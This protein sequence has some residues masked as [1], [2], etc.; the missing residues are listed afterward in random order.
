MFD[1]SND[2]SYAGTMVQ[3]KSTKPSLY[4]DWFCSTW[5]HVST[6]VTKESSGKYWNR[7]E[8]N[9][10]LKFLKLLLELRDSKKELQDDDPIFPI[11]IITPFA[12]M[13]KQLSH[14]LMESSFD[15][16]MVEC[17]TIHTFQGKEAP[18]VILCLVCDEEKIGKSGLWVNR[19]PHLINVAVTRAKRR[20][21]VIGNSTIWVKYGNINK[22]LKHLPKRTLD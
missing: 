17:G 9:A 5:M 18:T 7:G 2:L 3:G 13:K 12:E 20:L 6:S 8:A 15:K 4:P 1:I 16:K 10:A 19:S 21:I 14:L 11:Y 22:L